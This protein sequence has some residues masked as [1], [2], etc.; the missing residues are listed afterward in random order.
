MTWTKQKRPAHCKGCK[1]Y[2]AFV[3]SGG[4]L[5]K[6]GIPECSKIH[7]P[8]KSMAQIVA[9]CKKENNKEAR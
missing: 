6:I 5:P 3:I 4:N 7:A 9:I 2:K 8:S 1:H